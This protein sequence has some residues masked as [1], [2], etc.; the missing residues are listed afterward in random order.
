M[1]FRSTQSF[2]ETGD[3]TGKDRQK[4]YER[5]Y[6]AM[7]IRCLSNTN[8]STA[9]ENARIQF[10]KMLKAMGFTNV[11]VRFEEEHKK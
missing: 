9:E 4:L 1:L 6:N 8:I 10:Y 5:A 11:K 2:F 3:W 7:R